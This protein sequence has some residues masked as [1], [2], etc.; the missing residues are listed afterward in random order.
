MGRSKGGG[1]E[2]EQVNEALPPHPALGA[3]CADPDYWLHDRKAREA[4]DG[5][6][7]HRTALGEAEAE[8]G[9]ESK[10]LQAGMVVTIQTGKNLKYC[11]GMTL[12]CVDK[13]ASK[14]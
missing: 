14:A 5:F 12:A 7:V 2:L 10:I 8:G 3:A 6:T 1:S 13:V 11:N 4:Y 9:G